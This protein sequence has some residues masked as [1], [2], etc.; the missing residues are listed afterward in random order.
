MP[1]KNFWAHFIVLLIPMFFVGALVNMV[2]TLNIYDY[3]HMNWLIVFFGAVILD[4]IFTWIYTRK[5]T[6]QKSNS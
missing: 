6:E 3:I 2:V 1:K 4:L 5:R